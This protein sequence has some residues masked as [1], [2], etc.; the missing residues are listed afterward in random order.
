VITDSAS[1]EVAVAHILFVRIQSDLEFE[2]LS[3]RVEERRPRFLEV[4]GLVQKVYGFNPA[5]G[6]ACGIYFFEDEASL[7]AFRESELA[8][9]I[10]PAYEANDV[11]PEVFEVMFPLYP[12]RGPFSA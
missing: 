10:P 9:T 2:E 5:T 7:K 11:R 4:P 12:D 3:R 1:R 6:D 8:K